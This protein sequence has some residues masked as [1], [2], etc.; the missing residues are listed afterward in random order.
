[1]LYG[2][3]S[4]TVHSV[5]KSETRCCSVMRYPIYG[6]GSHSMAVACVYRSVTNIQ[7]DSV[8]SYARRHPL[9]CLVSP[10]EQLS[11]Q[12]ALLR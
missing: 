1:M 4:T 10:K 3:C 5:M 8:H 6:H 12:A 11:C 2:R 9:L 7:K